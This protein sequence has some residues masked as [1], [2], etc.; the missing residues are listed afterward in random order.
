MALTF[1]A[2]IAKKYLAQN[3]EALSCLSD[4]EEIS[5][6]IA[7]LLEFAKTYELL[8][9]QEQT[10]VN[11]GKMV[12]EAASL[13]VDLKGVTVINECEDFE[14]KADP[15]LVELFHNMID[16]SLKYGPPKITKIK[17]HVQINQEGVTELIYEDNGN[18]I[19]PEI[20]ARLFQKGTTTKG[21][22]YGL[23]LIRRICEMYGWSVQETGDYGQGVRF[24]MKIL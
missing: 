21:T 24:V 5:R 10:M 7:R 20:K 11:V 16:N 23:W 13:F 4:I 15:M 9:S 2:Y 19:D 17:V 3:P 22:G 8:G 18:G 6:N 12:A 14:V 1:Q